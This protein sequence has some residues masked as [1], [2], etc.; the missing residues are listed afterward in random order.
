MNP[1]Q[2][3]RDADVEV[4]PKRF[5]ETTPPQYPGSDYNF[6]LQGV[7]DIQ[8]SM[9][10]LEQGVETIREEQKDQ[11]K[12]LDSLSHKVTAAIA[13]IVFIGAVLT[14][15]SKFTNDLLFRLFSK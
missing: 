12:K 9:G 1:R 5:A 15:F 13:V 2:T 14:F 8:K 6:I 7:F 11:R 10:R 3:S 4:T